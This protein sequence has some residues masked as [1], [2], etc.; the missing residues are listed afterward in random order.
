MPLLLAT[1][2]SDSQAAVHTISQPQQS[3]PEF[4]SLSYSYTDHNVEWSTD[5][6]SGY[7]G[8]DILTLAANVEI[9]VYFGLLDKLNYYVEDNPVDGLLGLAPVRYGSDFSSILD[10][11][12]NDLDSPVITVWTNSSGS[13]NGTNVGTLGSVD[14]EHCQNNWIYVPQEQNVNAY[15]F[16]LYSIE[17]TL[18]GENKTRKLLTKMLFKPYSTEMVMGKHL[19]PLVVNATKAVYNSST[20]LYKAFLLISTQQKMIWRLCIEM[21]GVIKRAYGPSLELITRPGEKVGELEAPSP[22]AVVLRSLSKFYYGVYGL[23]LPEGIDRKEITCHWDEEKQSCVLEAS[24][25][26]EKPM[27]GLMTGTEVVFGGFTASSFTPNPSHPHIYTVTY[28]SQNSSFAAGI[29]TDPMQSFFNTNPVQW[30]FNNLGVKDI[31]L[32]YKIL[33]AS[34][35]KNDNQKSKKDVSFD[36]NNYGE[37]YTITNPLIKI[38][39]YDDDEENAGSMFGNFQNPYA[40][41]PFEKKDN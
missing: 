6:G 37:Q 30:K 4:A 12:V 2:Y 24:C 29:P 32:E 19:K 8:Y 39:H 16:E 7:G 26:N 35:T 34:L 28:N 3:R 11:I 18:D 5:L 21:D 27:T 10:Q 13:G 9:Q 22:I 17:M 25:T 31:A 38:N 40:N 14:T 41:N 36:P 20:G 33:E 15:T 1:L 23:R